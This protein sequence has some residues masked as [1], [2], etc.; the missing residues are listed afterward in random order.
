MKDDRGEM[1]ISPKLPMKFL[2]YLL[3]TEIVP[4]PKY[5]RFKWHF[6][7]GAQVLKFGWSGFS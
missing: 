6:V 2:F 5:K 3:F 4:Q 7:C 1:V